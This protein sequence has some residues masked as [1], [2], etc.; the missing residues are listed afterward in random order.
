MKH[1][2]EPWKAV[3]QDIRDGNEDNIVTVPYGDD[4]EQAEANARRIVSCVNACEGI[5]PDAV[6]ELLEALHNLLINATPYASDDGIW[7][8]ILKQAKVA[9]AK[10]KKK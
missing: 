1:T 6:P 5:N 3:G 2:P 4:P 9:I 7:P 8:V 10:A